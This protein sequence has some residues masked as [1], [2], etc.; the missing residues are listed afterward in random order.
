MAWRSR[1]WCCYGSGNSCSLGLIPGPGNFLRP[2]AWPKT[3]QNK[4][5]KRPPRGSLPLLPCECIV[6][7]LVLNQEVCSCQT[8]NLILDFLAFRTG[9]NKCS[10]LSHAV[11]SILYSNPNGLRHFLTW[12]IA[13]VWQ[14]TGCHG[15]QPAFFFFF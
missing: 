3:Q 5:I 14:L 12:I 10:Y 8:L 11:Y 4:F 9:R 1:T 15:F 7:C 2:Q 6:R 13:T